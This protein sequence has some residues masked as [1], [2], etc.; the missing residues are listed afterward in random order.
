MNSVF[1]A[2][3]QRELD[4]AVMYYQMQQSGL[5]HQFHRAVYNALRRIEQFP[6]AYTPL[7]PRTRRCLINRFPF[8]IIYS[9]EASQ[10]TVVAI[11][12]LHRKPD[13]WLGRA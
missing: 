3:A 6:E 12:N 8:G 7:G 13:Y 5:G 11:A 10:I 9:L 1:T 2:A 4:D